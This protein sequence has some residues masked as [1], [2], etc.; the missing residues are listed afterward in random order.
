MKTF[1]NQNRILIW[2]LVFLFAL[3]IAAIGTIFYHNIQMK[4]ELGYLPQEVYIPRM[5][6]PA[7]GRFM[8]ETLNLDEEQFRQFNLLRHSFHREAMKIRSSLF[9]LR[10]DLL[11]E[12]SKPEP[13]MSRIRQLTDEIGKDHA[14]LKLLTSKYYL[15]IKKLCNA[16]QKEKLN[17]FFL[18]LLD[19]EPYVPMN[20]REHHRGWRHEN[21]NTD[22]QPYMDSM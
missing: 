3:N 6:V 1:F 19:H 15:D 10:T 4:K 21:R 22:T 8:R 5:P 18:K 17:A 2:S 14:S 20:R 16:G 9:S 11:R 12:L 13:S 7:D